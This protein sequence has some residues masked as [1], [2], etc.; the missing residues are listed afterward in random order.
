MFKHFNLL[1]KTK[2]LDGGVWIDEHA[3]VWDVV[4]YE[5]FVLPK[6]SRHRRQ[7]GSLITHD[8]SVIAEWT[9]IEM[10]SGLRIPSPFQHSFYVCTIG[11]ALVLCLSTTPGLLASTIIQV[12]FRYNKR[13]GSTKPFV[14]AK[15]YYSAGL[16]NRTRRYWEYKNSSFVRRF[17]KLWFVIAKFICTITYAFW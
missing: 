8:N 17:Y 14:V 16:P 9:Y 2:S 1:L 15:I 11:S 12:K 10:V 7:N 4:W 13:F 3:N 5:C 6:V